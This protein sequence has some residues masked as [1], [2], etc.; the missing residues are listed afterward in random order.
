[1]IVAATHDGALI[2]MAA[3]SARWRHD[4]PLKRAMA[5]Q[6]RFIRLGMVCAVL[7]SLSAVGL[8]ALSG[9]FLVGAALA[10]MAGSLAVQGFNYLLPS[11]GIR[12]AAILRTGTRYGER[13]LGHRAALYALAQVRAVLFAAVAARRWPG[14]RPGAAARW[15]ISWARKSMRWR[16]RLS[17]RCPVRGHGRPRWPGWHRFWLWGGAAGSFCWLL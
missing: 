13:M 15:P 8:L 5:G 4:C 12:A 14:M 3:S 1:M 17:G 9:W 6:R 2:A 10:G 16:M 11:A 7:A